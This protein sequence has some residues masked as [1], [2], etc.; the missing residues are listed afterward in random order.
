MNAPVRQPSTLITRQP[1]LC[2]A[3][4]LLLD[5]SGSMEEGHPR[6]IDLLWKAVQALKTPQARWKVAT[7]N[8]RC[9]WAA[10]EAV[11]DPMGGT[12]LAHAFAVI[13][14]ARPA[15]VTVVTDGQPDDMGA[16]HEAAL[17]LH[18][19]VSVLFVGDAS[20]RDAIAFC[21]RLC[22][23]TKGT[24]ATEVLT[25]AAL[26]KTTETIRKMLGAGQATPT[27]IPLG[28]VPA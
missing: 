22:A 26:S 5:T 14:E 25:L 23:A 12:D 21:Q 20:D 17:A 24:F 8:S 6:R 9:R 27:S 10:V 11:P 13:G 1:R 18:C 3:T 15:R 4:V 7:F 16:A 28:G 19:P 2:T